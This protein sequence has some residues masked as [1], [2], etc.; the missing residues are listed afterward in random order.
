MPTPEWDIG[1]YL[2]FMQSQ[3]VAHSVSSIS[4]PGAGVFRGNKTATLAIARLLNENFAAYARTYP[5]RIS[6]M[7][8][9]PLPFVQESLIEVDYALNTL[10]ASGIGLLTNYE[11]MYLGNPALK[12]F[13]STVNER[14]DHP[15]FFVHPTDPVMEVNG[16][17]IEA[18]PTLYPT[19][20]VEY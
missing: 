5:K 15:I 13:F 18:N 1:T 12:D 4:S 14:Y 9:P 20:L 6:F 3:G 19:G 10:K 2:T 8:I 7:A 17:F 11:G 16:S